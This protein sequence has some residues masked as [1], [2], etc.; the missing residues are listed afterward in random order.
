MPDNSAQQ[1]PI[2]GYAKQKVVSKT[3]PISFANLEYLPIAQIVV[4]IQ[5]VF[6]HPRLFQAS[7]FYLTLN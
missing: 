5:P 6:F 4:P 3:Y 7:V 2:Y 1:K